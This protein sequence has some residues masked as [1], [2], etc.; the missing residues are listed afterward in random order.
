MDDI[1]V[2]TILQ[3]RESLV[4]PLLLGVPFEICNLVLTRHS[5]RKLADHKLEE[6][7]DLPAMSED[8]VLAVMRKSSTNN[9]EKRAWQQQKHKKLLFLL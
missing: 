3:F 9:Q 4:R 6:R 2:L 5:K 7:K 8:P 1:L